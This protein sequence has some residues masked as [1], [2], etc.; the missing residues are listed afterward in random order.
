MTEPERQQ[1]LVEWN[2]TEVSYPKD[3]CLHEL[4]EEQVERTPEAAAVVFE[5]K[6]LT[7]RELDERGN[8]LARYL[9]GLGVG[10]DALIGI[11]VER[12]LEMAVGLLGILKAGGAYVP[13]DPEYPKE[14]LAF[15]LK[16]AGVS[17]LLT[18]ARLTA[19]LPA[20]QTEIVR[21]DADW[22][23]IAKEGVGRATSSVSSEH[24]AYMI[25]TSGSTGRPKG[26]MIPHRA[27]VSHMR[28]MQASFPLDDRDSILQKYPFSFDPSVWEFFAPLIVG[29]R[30]VVAKPGGHV[31][32][33]Y[34]VK[35]I[36]RHRV[37]NL[38]LVPS[39]LR[40]LLDTPEFGD[41]DTLRRVFVGGDLLTADLVER[42]YETMNAQLYNLYGPTEV[43]IA[44]VF[45]PVPREYSDKAVPI[46]KPVANTRAYILN[47]CL[48]PV[49]IGVFGELCLGG[50]QV[51]R[52]Y[53][54][55]PE[56]TGQKFIP[57][58]FSTEPGA[59]MYRTG[60]LA[61]Y[62][63]DGAIEY[64]GRIDH[65]VKIC[66]FRIELGE[67]EFCVDRVSRGAS[68]GRARARGRSR[69]EATGRLFLGRGGCRCGGFACPRRER[70][71]RA[72]GSGGVCDA[73]V[74]AAY[75]QRQTGPPCAPSS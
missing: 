6:Q 67:I 65:Q 32:P 2:R 41:C 60:D 57:D 29:G 75:P 52:G 73:G 37:A 13:L 63:P 9:Q 69:R 59:L 50:A 47:S 72:H 56:L 44:S 20:H 36:R 26:A 68:G 22:P 16:D 45:F 14:R 71:A 8:Q 1:L 48:E 31:D 34:L 54:N 12:S 51:G 70:L 62:F 46:G 33:G 19:S 10:P 25:Y 23:L 30:L 74:A 28:W 39:Q 15:M 4:F 7:Y 3:R 61:R 58:P 64:L 24:L 53:H 66:G 35:M 40:M 43:T 11:C 49:P 21:L 17:V 38:Q 55:R 42:F 27:I 5:E 18:H